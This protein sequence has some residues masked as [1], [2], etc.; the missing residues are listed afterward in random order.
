[1]PPSSIATISK[2][3]RATPLTDHMHIAAIPRFASALLH[4]AALVSLTCALPVPPYPKPVALRQQHSAL[5]PFYSAQDMPGAYS[6]E[7]VRGDPSRCPR[8]FAIESVQAIPNRTD[9]YMSTSLPSLPRSLTH[10]DTATPNQS[11]TRASS[12]TVAHVPLRAAPSPRCSRSPAPRCPS[13]R[14][15]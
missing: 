11:P 14:A 2:A 10:T 15:M 5:M 3:S 6:L 7:L 13:F 4:V 1:M 12:P 9:V 8:A